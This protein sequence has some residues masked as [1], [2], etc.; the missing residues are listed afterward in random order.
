MKELLLGNQAVARGAWQAGVSVCAS[1]PGTPST[2][3]T[4]EIAKY[5]EIKAQWATNEKV[6]MEVAFGASLAG[7]RSMTCMK[8]VGMNVA[9]D[10]MFT[11][12]Y[13]GV[14][15]GMVIV[16]A[17]DPGMHS[18][19][20]EQDSR[21][22]ARAAHIPMLE[23]ADSQQ[24]LDYTRYAFALSEAYDTPVMLRLTTRI[25]HS[26]SFVEVGGRAVPPVK[27]Y[28]KNVTK[29]VMMPAMA[30]TRHHAVEER[31]KRLAEQV[32]N[33][34]FTHLHMGST[35]LGIISSGITAQYAREALPEASHLILGMVYP[36]P[37]EIIRS[38]AGAVKRM[39]VAEELEPFIQDQLVAAGIKCEGK[40][41][42][43]LQGEYSST[44][45]ARALGGPETVVIA[46]AENLPGR[47][48]VLCPGCPHR[49][50]FYTFRRLGITVLGDIGCYTLGAL[51]PLSAMDA[52]LCMG[53][54]IGMAM[55]MEKAL[56][57]EISRKTVAVIGDSTFLH[58]GMTALADAVYNGGNINVAILDNSITG[59][60]GHQQNPTS[61]FDIY[62]RPASAICLEDLCRSLGVEDV[63][64][65]DPF[66]LKGSMACMK[67][68]LAYEG[69]SVIVFRRPCALLPQVAKQ[70][71]KLVTISDACV[72]C[73]V[74]MGLGCPAILKTAEGM[75]VDATLCVGCGLC[76]DLCPKGAIKGEA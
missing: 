55:G 33:L 20:N 13:T 62:G 41:L 5:P 44:M 23:P 16:V 59:M 22:Y 3:I 10:P 71:R 66:D 65:I 39:V 36:L 67:E 30:I 56:G 45:L 52:C 24:C 1:Y 50:V 25:A 35:E 49:G 48:P 63:H 2:E 26:R 9:A 15:G 40:E 64:V 51:A 17:D 58:S 75:M 6:A 74:C 70:K 53:A 7:V 46:P 28:Q 37:M 21:Y 18:S 42:F 54:S 11:S 61:G 14:N 73:S 60:T 72:R 34:P 69:V 12:A 38:F 19:Q 43:T 32:S 76:T 29:N 47:P 31:E 27:P 8:H 4:E 68:A 57:R